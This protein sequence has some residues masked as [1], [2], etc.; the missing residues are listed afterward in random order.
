MGIRKI[1][2]IINPAAG[3]NEPVLNE[4]NQIFQDFEVE[5]DPAVT[6]KSGDA[7]RFARKAVAAGVDL[8]AGYGGDG[9]IMEIANGLRGSDVPLGILPGGTGNAVARELGIPARLADAAKLLCQFT[10]DNLRAIDVGQIEERYFLLHL[11]TG[12]KASQRAS[13]ELKNSIGLI[14]YLLPILRV[15]ANPQETRYRLRI[16]GVEVEE[17]AIFCLILNAW[18]LG[19]DLPFTPKSPLEGDE[20]GLLDVFLVKKMAI[21]AVPKMLEQRTTEEVWQHWQAQEVV[22]S[23]EEPQDVWM[24]GEAGGKTPFTAVSAPKALHIVVPEV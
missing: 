22:V 24:D 14:A 12:V 9:T 15:L 13:R 5:W 10:S 19:I 6:Q 18:G 2:V 20:G 11:Y 3:Q 17:T 4:L 16:D 23:T 8:V 1:Q 7:E 21:D